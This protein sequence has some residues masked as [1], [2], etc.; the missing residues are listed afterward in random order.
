MRPF[1]FDE[2]KLSVW[3]GISFGLIKEFWQE[4]KDDFFKFL[5]EFDRNGKLK[6]GGNLTFIA[7]IPKV[8][9]P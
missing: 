4:L 3:D 5:T 6:K 1:S 2:V 7:L 9:I 8:N